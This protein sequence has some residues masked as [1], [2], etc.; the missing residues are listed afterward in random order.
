MALEEGAGPGLGGFWVTGLGLLAPQGR[1]HM[2]WAGSPPGFIASWMTA[3]RWSLAT[4]WYMP[5]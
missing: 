2:A 4:T 3:Q 5:L 1:D